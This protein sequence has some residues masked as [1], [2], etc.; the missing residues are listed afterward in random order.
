MKPS[1]QNDFETDVLEDEEVKETNSLVVYNDDYNSFEKVIVALMQICEHTLEQAEQ[2]TTIIHYKG[3][4]SVK[5]G[6]FEKLLEMKRAINEKGIDA[7][8]L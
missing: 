2:C 1:K 4:C 6:E 3:K 8:V 7:K 5:Q